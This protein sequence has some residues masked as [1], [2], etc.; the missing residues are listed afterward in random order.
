MIEWPEL[1]DKDF[2]GDITSH[3]ELTLWDD[4]K[5]AIIAEAH[6]LGV[7]VDW[8]TGTTTLRML[9]RRVRTARTVEAVNKA[10]KTFIEA[11]L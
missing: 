8:T 7:G 1:E 3:K 9:Y 11:S 6:R 4:R 2:D 10:A 5:E